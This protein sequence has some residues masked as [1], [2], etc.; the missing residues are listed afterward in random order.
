MIIGTADPSSYVSVKIDGV[1]Y[2]GSADEFG[3]WSISP[4]A[5]ADGVISIE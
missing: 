2:V 5:Q 4:D 1:E 3:D